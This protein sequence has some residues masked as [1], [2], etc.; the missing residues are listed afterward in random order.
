MKI[1]FI[2]DLQYT[3]LLLIPD[4]GIEYIMCEDYL[5]YT[6]LLLILITPVL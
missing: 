4:T 1:V 3:L 6:L 2:I 5:Q